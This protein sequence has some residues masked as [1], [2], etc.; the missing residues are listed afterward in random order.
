MKRFVRWVAL[1]VGVAIVLYCG[2]LFVGLYR[3]MESLGGIPYSW[4]LLRLNAQWVMLAAF[5]LTL[6][7]LATYLFLNARRKLDELSN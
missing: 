1:I 4:D 2:A 5:G 3:M 6:V 7:G